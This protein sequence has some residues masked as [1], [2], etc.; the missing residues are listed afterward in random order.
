MQ[1]PETLHRYMN[2][3]VQVVGAFTGSCHVLVSRLFLW[4]AA[5][6]SDDFPYP[7]LRRGKAAVF[8]ARILTTPSLAP[9]IGDTWPR[10]SHQPMGQRDQNGWPLILRYRRSTEWVR[11][12]VE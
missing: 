10:V 7:G 4:T 12:V 3:I 11:V 5:G 1:I 6:L 9:I 2:Y 8:I